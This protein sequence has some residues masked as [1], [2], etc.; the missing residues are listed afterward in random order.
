MITPVAKKEAQ[1]LLDL[2]REV[3]TTYVTRSVNKESTTSVE[4]EIPIIKDVAETIFT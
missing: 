2:V 4:L 1:L 3:V